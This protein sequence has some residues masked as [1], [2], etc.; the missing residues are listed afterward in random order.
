MDSNRSNHL[1][2]AYFPVDKFLDRC[3]GNELKVKNTEILVISE[4]KT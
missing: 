2:I 1:R 4:D 3:G